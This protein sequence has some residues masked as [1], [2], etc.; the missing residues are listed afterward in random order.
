MVSMPSSIGL[1]NIAAS[2]GV[3]VITP[4]VAMPTTGP[5]HLVPI[6]YAATIVTRPSI[7]WGRDSAHAWNP[8]SR[9]ASA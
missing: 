2:I 5:R 7:T 8:N 1:P 4:A 3:T 9:I 6:A